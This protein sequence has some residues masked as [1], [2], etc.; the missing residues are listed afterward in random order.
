MPLPRVSI[1]ESVNESFNGSGFGALRL[2]DLLED[3]GLESS[4][5][6]QSF[7]GLGLYGF[8]VFMAVRSKA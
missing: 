1:W 6:T 3:L 2:E 8:T 4:R 7:F 5:A